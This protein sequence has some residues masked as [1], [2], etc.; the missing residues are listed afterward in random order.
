MQRLHVN[1]CHAEQAL[2]HG[3]IQY[4]SC[5]TLCCVANS[6]NMIMQSAVFYYSA[7]Y[8]EYYYKAIWLWLSSYHLA[9]KR[10]KDGISK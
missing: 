5:V 1:H 7:I 3:Y 6:N 9:A 8:I 4:Y 2:M 10:T